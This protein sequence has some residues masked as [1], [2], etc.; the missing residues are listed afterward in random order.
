MISIDKLRKKGLDSLDELRTHI[1]GMVV[2]SEDGEHL[3]WLGPM[4]TSASGQKI[5]H[6][7]VY[8]SIN[9]QRFLYEDALGGD[10]GGGRLKKLCDIE[11]CVHPN[12]TDALIKGQK[13]IPQD[14]LLKFLD[15]LGL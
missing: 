12:H 11:R 5:V 1:A 4:S 8:K 6:Y 7:P 3:L 2:T 9:V 15:E 10:T 13:T 14:K